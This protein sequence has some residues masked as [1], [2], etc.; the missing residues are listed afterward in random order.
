MMSF[1]FNIMMPCVNPQSL[2]ESVSAVPG[3]EMNVRF[4]NFIEIMVLGYVEFAGHLYS[5]L[6]HTKFL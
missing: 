1:A 5:I 2:M 3:S 4:R 6:P